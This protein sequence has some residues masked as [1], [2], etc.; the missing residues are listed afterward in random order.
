[1]EPKEDNK[2]NI[3]RIAINP[4]SKKKRFIFLDKH[5]NQIKDE[6]TLERVKKLVI[7]PAYT[8]IRIANNPSNYL[9]A[10]GYDD[11]GRKQYVYK[12]SF[13]DKQSKNKYC[14]L[15]HFGQKI[16]KIRQDIRAIMLNDKPINPDNKEKIIALIVYILDNCYFRIGNI[17]YYNEHKSHGVSTLQIKHFSFKGSELEIEFIGKKGVLNN[18]VI[19]DA[20]T[21]K[22]IKELIQNIKK[23]KTKDKS[24]DDFIFYYRDDKSNLKLISPVDINKFLTSYHPDITLK[25]FR[26]W[27]ANFIFL[28]EMIKNKKEFI[29]NGNLLNKEKDTR[30]DKKDIK[31]KDTIDTK[32]NIKGDIKENIKEKIEK[33]R[34]K[35]RIKE[36]DKLI[37]NIIKNIAIRLHNTP[38]VSKKSYLDNNLVQ[39]YLDNPR[40]FWKKI[41]NSRNK[42]DL[43][44]LL[45]EFLSYNCNDNTKK[46]KKNKQI[47]PTLNNI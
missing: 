27:G 25:M 4:K 19:K 39:I 13:I 40:N 22:L 28:D 26:T 10:I 31:E 34:Q 8:D 1:M 43:T 6:K 15:K 2:L 5:N 38:N 37:K 21:I 32:E 11:K 42:H 9:Q 33:K 41:S 24:I 17:H 7:P 20:L 35:E 23:E 44:I 3:K 29:S 46:T 14:Q 16:I 18:C 30:D 12:A 45:S 36:T 47:T